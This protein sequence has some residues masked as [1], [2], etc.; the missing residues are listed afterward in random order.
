MLEPVLYICIVQSLFAGTVIV[1]KRPQQLADRYMGAWLFIIGLESLLAL[2][3]INILTQLPY[4]LPFLVVPFVYGPLMLLYVRALIQEEVSF[5]WIELIHF[6]P[7]FLLLGLAFLFPGHMQEA[8]DRSVS[9]TPLRLAR[10]IITM[11]LF[12][13][14]TTYSSVVY[15]LLHQHRKSIQEHFS[16]HSGKITLIWLLFASITVYVS[17]FLTFLSASIQLFVINLPFDPKIFSFTGLTLISFAFS[18]YGYRQASIY[19]RPGRMIPQ[20]LLHEDQEPRKYQKSGLKPPD[21]ELIVKAM[22]TL[23]EG[24][25]LYLDPELTIDQVAGELTI[26][27]HHLTQSLNMVSG[28]NFYTYINEWRLKAFL[29]RLDDPKYHDFTLL[30]NAYDCGFNSKSTFNSVFKRTTGVTPSAYVATLYKDK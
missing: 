4:Q 6:I 16:Y 14:L 25:K 15:Y 20:S 22:D 21:M 3:N 11:L 19:H 5:R 13:S 2:L 27:R 23:M 8:T 12:L 1:S 17:Y 10:I 26:P 18:F 30:A 7:F 29:R 28:K 24:K 9:Y